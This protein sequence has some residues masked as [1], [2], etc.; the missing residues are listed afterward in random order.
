MQSIHFSCLSW[1]FA[2]ETG[3]AKGRK[4]IILYI[5][6][7]NGTALCTSDLVGSKN[8]DGVMIYSV[9]SIVSTLRFGRNCNAFL[10]PKV[11]GRNR[12]KML[13]SFWLWKESSKL[14]N[15]SFIMV[16][17]A[18]NKRLNLSTSIKKIWKKIRL[19]LAPYSFSQIF[20]ELLLGAK[21]GKMQ[22]EWKLIAK[23]FMTA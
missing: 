18:C 4:S 23:L 1:I 15:F 19:C 7:P 5:R 8:I 6:L 12:T 3:C 10:Y 22:V 17:T 14:W 9:R 2:M 16:S 21:C 11:V 20:F 13:F